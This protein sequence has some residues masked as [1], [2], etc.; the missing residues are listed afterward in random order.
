MRKIHGYLRCAFIAVSLLLVGCTPTQSTNPT[1][2]DAP[3]TP[4]TITVQPTSTSTPYPTPDISRRPLVWFAPL[5]PLPIL[6]SRPFIG[7]EDFMDLFTKQAPWTEAAKRIQVFK[8]YSWVA[9]NAAYDEVKQ[10]VSDLNRRGIAIAFEGG[11][12]TPTATCGRGIEGF[13][14]V[15]EGITIANVIKAA[16][17]TVRFVAFDHPFD[18]GVL[19]TSANACHWS[20]EE[21]AQNIARYVKAIRNIFPDV[22][23]GTIETAGHNPD[24]VVQWVDAYNAVLGEDIG[25]FH[26]DL[27]YSQPDWPQKTKEIEDLLRA[28]DIEFGI[29]Y[30][31]SW[32]SESDEAWLSLAGKHVKSYELQAG[33]RPDHVIFQSWHDHPDWNLSETEPYTFTW[34][35]NTYFTEKASLGF[36]TEG[37]GANIAFGKSIR[38]SKSNQYPAQ[39]AVDGNPDTTW[40]AGDFAPQWIEVDLGNDYTISAINLQTSQGALVGETVHEIYVKGPGTADEYVL[41]YTFEGITKDFDVLSVPMDEP[42]EGIRLVRIRTISSPSWIAWREIEVISAE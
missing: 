32:N 11:P 18:A 19:D 13:A 5:P 8:F 26:M 15:N 39:W 41:L 35:I 40:G 10:A 27:D 38:A 31:G 23:F 28:R 2:G 29:I 17:G 1:E 16:G 12:L 6:P 36:R 4:L 22:I 37:P 7:S 3:T 9:W 33:G 42:M 25:F 21:V 20:P 24:N 34:F 14:G 30:F